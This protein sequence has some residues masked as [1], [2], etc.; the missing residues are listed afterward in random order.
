MKCLCAIHVDRNQQTF[1]EQMTLFV[2]RY[3]VIYHFSIF[4]D[5][6]GGGVDSPDHVTCKWLPTIKVCSCVTSSNWR[7]WLQMIF[8]SCKNETMLFSSLGSLMCENGRSL[9]FPKRFWLKN[10]LSDRMCLADQCLTDQL[11]LCSPLKHQ[12]IFRLP[13][14]II[15]IVNCLS[16]KD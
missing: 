2:V 5:V 6:G 1:L 4:D 13:S 12:D 11:F 7:V 15:I 3:D 10:K 16:L 8:C 14:S 9:C